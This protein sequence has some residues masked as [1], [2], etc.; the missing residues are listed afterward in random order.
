MN[1]TTSNIHGFKGYSH[2]QTN[3]GFYKF[4][5]YFCFLNTL[6][7]ENRAVFKSLNDILFETSKFHRFDTYS[8]KT[9]IGIG[10]HHSKLLL[11]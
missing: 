10:P 4:R 6:P 11:V 2:V 7:V 8:L 1:Q 5:I 9:Y 3:D